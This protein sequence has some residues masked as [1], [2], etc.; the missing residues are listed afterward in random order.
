MLNSSGI[1][2]KDKRNE[3]ERK[4]GGGQI[5]YKVVK[6]KESKKGRNKR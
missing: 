2:K 4:R 6:L 5:R 3:K 1:L